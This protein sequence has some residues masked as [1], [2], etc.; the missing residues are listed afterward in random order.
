MGKMHYRVGKTVSGFEDSSVRQLSGKEPKT[1][2]PNLQL[3]QVSVVASS[4]GKWK[5]FWKG[6]G[7]G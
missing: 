1:H 2:K 6:M 7:Q 4:G 5:V 3:C